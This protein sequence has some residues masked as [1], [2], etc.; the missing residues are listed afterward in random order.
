VSKLRL[1]IL[2]DK[3]QYASTVLIGRIKI[4]GGLFND[5]DNLRG[6]Q[7]RKHDQIALIYA[8]VRRQML[9]QRQIS[10]YWL[11]TLQQNNYYTRG[12]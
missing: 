5:G 3:F 8:S 10:G 7:Y 1:Q 12:P 4:H 2:T 9:K 11:Y 6:H